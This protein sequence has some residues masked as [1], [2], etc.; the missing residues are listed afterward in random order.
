MADVAKPYQRSI[1]W[2]FFVKIVKDQKA[3]TSFTKK[4]PSFIFERVLILCIVNKTTCEDTEAEV[5]KYVFR[6]G[7]TN[8][9]GKAVVLESLFKKIAGSQPWNFIKKRLQLKCFPRRLA[10]FFRALFFRKH[11]RWLLFKISSSNNPTT[12]SKIFHQYP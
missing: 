1:W 7:F 11:L 9:T 12:C 6:K 5:H 2:R 8:F 4:T 3:L 10:K